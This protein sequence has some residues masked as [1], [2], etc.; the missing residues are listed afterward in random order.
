MAV[1]Q[2]WICP[3]CG[4]TDAYEYECIDTERDDIEYFM[5]CKKCDQEVKPLM[6]HGK[7]VYRPLTR[8]EIQYDF[9]EEDDFFGW[10]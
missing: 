7:P 5:L 6:K 8:E 10:N 4:E 3:K 1:T 2:I 9:F